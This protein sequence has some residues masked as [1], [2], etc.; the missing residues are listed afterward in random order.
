MSRLVMPVL[1]PGQSHLNVEE[2]IEYEL[3]TGDDGME[4]RELRDLETIFAE[5][6]GPTDRTNQ[7]ASIAGYH[8]HRDL[9]SDLWS[10]WMGRDRR[11]WESEGSLADRV[12]APAQRDP[13]P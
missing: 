12:A 13:L 4:E 11:I 2:V 9:W 5:A 1:S 7:A 3:K 10:G 6:G 8:H